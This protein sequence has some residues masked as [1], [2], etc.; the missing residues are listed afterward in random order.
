MAVVRG[1]QLCIQVEAGNEQCLPSVHLSISALQSS[2]HRSHI[3]SGI[4]GTFSK[5]ADN[6]KISGTWS[7]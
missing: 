6:T 5:F 4:E 2:Y 1:Q 3:G 7:S